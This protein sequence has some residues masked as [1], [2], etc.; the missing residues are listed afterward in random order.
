MLT[1]KDSGKRQEF[2]TGSR[3]D[4]QEGKGRFDLISPLVEDELAQQLEAG[5]IKYG[6][7]NWE[8]GQPL[9]RYI[10]S[11]KRHINRLQRGWTDENHAIAALWNIQAFIHTREMIRRGNLPAE[12]DDFTAAAESYGE[13]A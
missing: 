5:A 9:M 8:L 7:R 13:A 11:A 2:E 12:L 1:V 10:D 6:E 4:T 3:R